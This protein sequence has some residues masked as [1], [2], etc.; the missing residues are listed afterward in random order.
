VK[1]LEPYRRFLV[2]FI[3]VSTVAGFFMGWLM[4]GQ[5]LAGV[6][7]AGLIAVA[8]GVAFAFLARLLSLAPPSLDRARPYRAADAHTS[9]PTKAQQD[10]T[11]EPA[12]K[13]RHD[14]RRDSDEGERF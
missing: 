7:G 14:V 4:A 3:V 11:K 10:C 13:Q 9:T 12:C 2:S 8:L 1:H 6:A 5:L